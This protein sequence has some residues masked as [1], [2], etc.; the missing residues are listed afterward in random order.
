MEETRNFAFSDSGSI[1]IRIEGISSPSILAEEGVIVS[2]N[3]ENNVQRSVDFT[4]AVYDN[5]EKTTHEAFHSKPAQRLEVYY[6]LM[7]L[8]IL[9][10][11]V[12][13]IGALLWLNKK[14]KIRDEKPGAVKI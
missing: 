8:I 2:G 6:E 11:A 5:P 1:I 7:I 4:T 9:I 14:P 12:L 13:F 3:I 10:P